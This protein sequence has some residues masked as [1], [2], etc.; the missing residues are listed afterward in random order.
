MPNDEKL[1]KQE[2]VTIKAKVFDMAES[3]ECAFCEQKYVVP[4]LHGIM[5]YIPKQ[6]KGTGKLFGGPVFPICPVCL[7]SLEKDGVGPALRKQIIE[8][9]AM[10]P[11]PP[12]P[13]PLGPKV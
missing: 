4:I 5:F 6:L 11:D 7:E 12:F 2:E 10:S 1:E 9:L 8:E 3:G 13:P